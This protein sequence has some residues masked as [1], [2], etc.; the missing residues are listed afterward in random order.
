MMMLGPMERKG[1][2][3]GAEARAGTSK[4]W[5]LPQE[6]AKGR[7]K[8]FRKVLL[9]AVGPTNDLYNQGPDL[10]YTAFNIRMVLS[11]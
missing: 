6:S 9:R 2:G 7:V 10:P 8:G 3:N 11:L 5:G 4:N 1:D